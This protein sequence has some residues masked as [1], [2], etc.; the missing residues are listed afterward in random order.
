MSSGTTLTRVPAAA[1]SGPYAAAP[2]R[3]G[4]R[5]APG[6]GLSGL[7]GAAA[8][9]AAAR[10]GSLLISL[11]AGVLSARALGPHD[12]GLLAVAIACSAVFS[13]LCAVGLDT[14]NLRLAGRSTAAH[15]HTVRASLRYAVTLGSCVAAVWA[16]AGLT[17]AEPVRLGLDPLTFGITAA[18]C[19][20]VLLSALLGATEIGRGRAPAYN[21]VVVA[22]LTTYLVGLAAVVAA[23]RTTPATVMAV[24]AAGQVVGLG[25]LLVRS[26]SA[27]PVDGEPVADTEYRSSARRAYLPNLAQFGM[28]R[29]QVP[30]IQLLVGASAVGVYSVALALAEVLLIIPIAVSLVLVPTVANGAA[31]WRSVARLGVRTLL[32]TAVGA[33]LLAAAGPTVVPLLYGHHFAPAV[34]V[35]WALLPG[36][37]VFALARVAQSYLTAVDRPAA[38]TVAAVTA[39]L[40][41]LGGMAVLVPRF[42][43]VGAGL[44]GSAGYL[45]YAAVITPAFLR[46]D[47]ARAGRRRPAR[48]P[49]RRDWNV[50]P[51]L[52]TALVPVVAAACGVAA[53]KLE[54]LPIPLPLVVAGIAVFLAVLLVPV[55]GL[56]GLALGAAAGQLPEPFAVGTPSL[57]LLILC[58][59]AGTL[60]RRKVSWRD[61]RCTGLVAALV[62]LLLV[63]AVLSNPQLAP[64][65]A[66]GPVAVV[67]VPLVCLPLISRGGPADHR[68]LLAF[69]FAATGVGLLHAAETI[70]RGGPQE[71]VEIT[72]TGV[73]RNVWGPMLVVALAILLSRLTRPS[74]L[75]LRIAALAALPMIAVALGYSY[76]RSSYLGAGAVLVCFALRRLVRAG[77]WVGATVAVAATL[78]VTTALVPSTIMDRV[79]ATTA[80]GGLDVS[81]ALRVDLWSA[82]VE[83]S[84]D[85]PVF[86]VGYL[87]YNGRLP[88]YFVQHF[89]AA[90]YQPSSQLHLLAHPH[91]FFLTVLA[92]TGVVGAL[93]L[94]ALL[95]LVYRRV[96]RDYRTRIGWAAE[97]ALLAGVGVAVSSLT[98][99]PL[100]ALPVLVPFVLL[101]AVATRRAT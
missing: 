87:G 20:V 67:A 72:N 90:W 3:R 74:P 93:L 24:Y 1:A 98:G 89:T 51:L 57:L 82:A 95:W 15:R 69:A 61:P 18:L 65:A 45:V 53:T 5:S 7:V 4:R 94:G 27:V 33:G 28:I 59:L 100:L 16:V 30:V 96:W 52:V 80:D 13:T 40:V 12:R 73:N 63:G 36:V 38:T 14:A 11:V 43:A 84:K 8:S 64:L 101:H 77:L 81:S 29:T 71:I 21:L 19:P 42:G 49:R 10:V 41:G 50:R 62:V 26:R 46:A 78:G 75:V 22:S 68:A 6:P 79:T 44:A 86:G 48:A 25:A 54:G 23:G 92:E 2:A 34:P 76:S 88:E 39:A 99:E 91:N 58:C 31:S 85:F 70:R 66:V 47:P 55:L 9:T 97:G 60:L 35:L 17:V 37:A 56:V 32:L 83:M